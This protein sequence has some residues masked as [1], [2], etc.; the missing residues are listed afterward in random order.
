L[1]NQPFSLES[2]RVC[3]FRLNKT[4]NT[5]K[6]KQKVK[7]DNKTWCYRI[8]NIKETM[9]GKVTLMLLA[10]PLLAATVLDSSGIFEDAP[11]SF[12]LG[13]CCLLVYW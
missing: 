6:V 9:V 12:F 10:S 13:C 11:G 7:H 4:K 3:F 8:V 1:Q 2:Y 5:T